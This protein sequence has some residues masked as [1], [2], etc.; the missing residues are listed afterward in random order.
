MQD[1]G[2]DKIE[3]KGGHRLMVSRSGGT[4][5]PV[6]FIA[7]VAADHTMWDAVRARLTRPTVAYDARGH[8]RSDVA[9]APLTVD[10]LAADA[11]S[12]LDA[13]GIDRAVVCGLSLGGL[14]AMRAAAMAPD[15]V[16]GLVL[17][18][19]AT[20]FPPPTLWQDRAKSAA[21]GGWPDLIQPTLERWLTEGWRDAHPD[22]TAKV[23][24][25]LEAMPPQGYADACAAL[26]T[27]D[28]AEAL[29][30]YSGR[31][32]VIA[33]AHDASASVA[34]AEEMVAMARDADLVVLDTAHIAAIEDP[35][36]FTTALDTFAADLEARA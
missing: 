16:A 28:T 34:R 1:D 12:V 32:L 29:K 3:A 14:T 17:A 11:L 18:N 15:R 33:G 10:D 23:W 6:L 2:T 5:L 24:K 35:E 27:G 36:G 31:T 7:S 22:E 19:T 21:S 30:G 13:C 26:E 9:G 8:G 20:S 4:G 25:M